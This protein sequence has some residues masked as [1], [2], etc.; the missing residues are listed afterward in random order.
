MRAPHWH[1]YSLALKGGKPRRLKGV[2]LLP[3]EFEAA[4]PG[5]DD[6]SLRC[7]ELEVSGPPARGSLGRWKRAQLNSV[8]DRD[9]MEWQCSLQVVRPSVSLHLQV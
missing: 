7:V 1:W 9:D 5:D 2:V 6:A 4:Q 3:F 8:T